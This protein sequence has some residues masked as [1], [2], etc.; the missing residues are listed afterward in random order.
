M[1]PSEIW[2]FRSTS[3]RSAGVLAFTQSASVTSPVIRTNGFSSH[4][5]HAIGFASAVG[6]AARMR[7]TAPRV[8]RPPVAT[9]RS[10]VAGCTAIPVGAK[11]LSPV[12]V[13]NVSNFPDSVS[14]F[15]VNWLKKIWPKVQSAK[16]TPSW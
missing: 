3:N 5:S 15:G 14:P 1:S 4:F 12:D 11:P 16:K 2:Y 7:Y 13:R 6:F 9:Y 10:P 8:P